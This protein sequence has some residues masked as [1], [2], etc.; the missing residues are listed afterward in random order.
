MH[1]Q[2]NTNTAVKSP[3]TFQ[4]WNQ[5]YQPSV[6]IRFLPWTLLPRVPLADLNKV[7]GIQLIPLR[8]SIDR[9]NLREVSIEV[10]EVLYEG[11]V[12]C[13]CC[14]AEEV[15]LDVET[16]GVEGLNYWDG[17][18]GGLGCEYHNFVELRE[19]S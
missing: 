10:R 16:E 18:V 14:F 13:S 15:V 9:H 2:E 12:V 3:L 8:H 19:V 11:S 17:G 1:Q 6:T 7:I 4:K 5:R